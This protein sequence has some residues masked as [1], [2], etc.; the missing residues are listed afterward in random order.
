M[1]HINNKKIIARRD[2]Y[3]IAAILLAG[4][5]AFVIPSAVRKHIAGRIAVITVDSVVTEEI[6]MEIHPN[7][8]FSIDNISGAV[9][10]IKNGQIR[11]KTSDCPDK[12]CEKTGF[13]SS[14]GEKIVCLPKKLVV[15][16][17]E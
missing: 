10:E 7:G 16:V 5:I 14:P 1:I 13:I 15:E 6:N 11:V 2:I 8:E 17:K 9:F 4:I 3:I 12:I